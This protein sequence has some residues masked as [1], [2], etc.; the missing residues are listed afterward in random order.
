MDRRAEPHA[1]EDHQHLQRR[2]RSRDARA[3]QLPHRRSY[4]HWPLFRV[5]LGEETKDGGVPFDPDGSYAQVSTPSKALTGASWPGS[6]AGP[7]PTAFP[8]RPRGS[9]HRGVAESISLRAPPGADHPNTVRV[10][11]RRIKTLVVP[12]QVP[13]GGAIVVIDLEH[14]PSV[15]HRRR[16]TRWPWRWTDAARRSPYSVLEGRRQARSQSAKNTREALSFWSSPRNG[17][18]EDKVKQLVAHPAVGASRPAP[19]SSTP[20]ATPPFSVRPGA[21][22]SCRGAGPPSGRRPSSP[23]PTS[24]VCLRT[25]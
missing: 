11:P 9:P 5:L 12:G 18:A 6:W 16:P 17:R 7:S 1:R 21:D 15:L 3:L 14:W 23:K 19:P 22:S 8:H 20:T 25:R 4:T 24:W 13:W 10:R 2:H